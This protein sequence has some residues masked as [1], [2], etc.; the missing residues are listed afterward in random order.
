MWTKSWPKQNPWE[1]HVLPRRTYRYA[2]N[3]QAPATIIVAATTRLNPPA[4]RYPIFHCRAPISASIAT[5]PTPN[6]LISKTKL[7][8]FT[9][10]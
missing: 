3:S 10:R 7:K 1:G 8:F 2:N 5:I 6:V 4:M 9:L